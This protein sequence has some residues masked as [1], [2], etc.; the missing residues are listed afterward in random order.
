M[1]RL[2]LL[3]HSKAE[4]GVPGVSDQERRL[5]R[6]GEADARTMGL[7]IARH[8]FV[9]E[10]A[11]VSPA[12]RTRDTWARASAALQGLPAG[13]FE[14]RIY[15][16]TPGTLLSVIQSA[17][18]DIQTLILIGHNPGLHELAILLIASGD[19]DLRERLREKFPTSGLAVIDFP[20]AA[21]ADLHPR[22]G[23]L[24]CFV[25]PKTIAAATN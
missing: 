19:V 22:S 24:E 23:R 3:R 25:S 21:W 6:E 8:R 2:L 5:T 1:R 13:D 15:D 12:T 16:A 7:Y 17:P 4:R 14:P 9:P 10:R 11:L 18:A 20:A